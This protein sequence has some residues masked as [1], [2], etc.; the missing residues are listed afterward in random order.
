MSDAPR[1]RPAPGNMVSHALVFYGLLAGAA[2]VWRGGVQGESIWLAPGVSA[3]HG[4]LEGLVAGLAIAGAYVV[5]SGLYLERTRWGRI[6]A[7]EMAS[8]LRGLGFGG[9][10][11]LATASG[12]AEELFFRGALQPQVGLVAASLLFG[13]LHVPHRREF[14]PW[15]FFAGAVGFVL[16]ALYEWSGSLLGPAVAHIAINLVGLVRLV[17]QGPSSLDPEG[18]SCEDT[19]QGH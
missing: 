9:A 16:G 19:S 14:L 10:L 3:P 7:H 5:L 11:V 2:W 1:L 17:R 8:Q 15:P 13:V 12:L 6:M 4:P 18:E